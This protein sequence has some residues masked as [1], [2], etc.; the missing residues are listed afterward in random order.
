MISASSRRSNLQIVR[1]P[2]APSSLIE[3]VVELEVLNDAAARVA[4]G[5]GGAVILEAPA[6]LGKTALLERG[7][8]FAADAGCL[9]R[10]TAAGP[11]E[12]HFPFGVVRSLLEGPLRDAPPSERARLLEGA[13]G[14]AGRLLLDGSVPRGDSAV[15]VAHSVLWLCS[16]LAERQ[17]LALVVDDAQWADRASLE[18]LAYLA[19]RLED[20][21]LL[22]LV[23]ARTGDPDAEAGVLTLLG[24]ARSATVLRPRPL[25]TRGALELIRRFA[26]LAPAAVC[27]DA[28]RAVDGNPWLLGELGRQLAAGGTL[29]TPTVVARTVVRRRLAALAPRDRGV[30]EALAVVGDAAPHVLAAAAGLPLGELGA[31]Q[32]ALI[33][34]GLLAEDGVR[35]AHGLIATV[36]VEDLQCTERER[37]HGEVARALMADRADPRLIAAHLLRCAPQADPAVSACLQDAARLAEPADAAAYLERALAER[38]PGDDR[39]TLLARLGTAGYDAGL[40]DAR[41]HL[42]EALREVSDR[43]CRIAVLTRLAAL[44]LVDAADDGLAQAFEDE[45]ARETDPDVRLEVEVA[46]LDAL[47]LSTDRLHERAYR[48]AAIELPPA[49]NPLLECAIHAHRAWVGVER[50]LPDAA[51][52]AELALRALEDDL[53]L[54]EAHWRAAYALCARVLTLT[55]HPAAGPAIRDMRETALERGS[56]RLRIAAEWYAAAH[57]LRTGRVAEAETLARLVLDLVEDG[58]SV[59]KGAGGG[60]RVRARRARG[61]RRGARRAARA[62]RSGVHGATPARA[63]GWRRASSSAR[64]PKPRGSARCR[65]RRAAPTRR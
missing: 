45:L 22:L 56:L 43:E 7:A 60:A 55:D 36:I 37:L 57:A 31:A 33:A 12:R 35:F 44:H 15:L 17:P 50:G 49:V 3:R 46:S 62:R 34:A 18:V 61:V 40:P 32:D 6:G 28:R 54:G 24:A 19:R 8:A 38:A 9:V 1:L 53:L 42:R 48:A 30:V 13:A 29:E 59:F 63:C 64:T 10:R 41:R 39:W 25:T 47:L 16:A 23:G 65:S 11:L 58:P 2:S 5:G 21:P 26:P 4:A 20:V 27:V 51:G 52:W 14:P